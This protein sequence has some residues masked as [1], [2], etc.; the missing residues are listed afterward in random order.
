MG[1]GDYY[2]STGEDEDEVIVEVGEGAGV[3][4]ELL[5]NLRLVSGR[6]MGNLLLQ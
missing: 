4:L 2:L 6:G 5:P 1:I 3:A